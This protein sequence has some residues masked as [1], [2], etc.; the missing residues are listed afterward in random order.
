MG[1]GES[2]IVGVFVVGKNGGEKL[3]VQIAR[4]QD[5]D[6]YAAGYTGNPGTDFSNEQWQQECVR[7]ERT[8]GIPASLVSDVALQG[9]AMAM[10]DLAFGID[11][12]ENPEPP[13][14]ERLATQVAVAR[15]MYLL[16]QGQEMTTR[17]ASTKMTRSHNAA[18]R[19]L[20]EIETSGFIPLRMVREGNYWYWKLE[21]S[22]HLRV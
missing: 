1:D 14:E 15:V 17:E 8:H 21:A 20:C 5:G 2:A 6:Y 9:L 3:N 13:E 22:R 10:D 7:I 19:I 16:C 18:W 12:L 11:K 4:G